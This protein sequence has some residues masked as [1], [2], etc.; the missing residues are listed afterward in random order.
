MRKPYFDGPY[1][2]CSLKRDEKEFFNYYCDELETWKLCHSKA[3]EIKEKHKSSNTRLIFVD[4][5]KLGKVL[6]KFEIDVLF[7]IVVGFSSEVSGVLDRDAVK[8]F[9]SGFLVENS[10]GEVT[11]E[12]S[13]EQIKE[14]VKKFIRLDIIREVHYRGDQ[15]HR[16]LVN[17]WVIYEKIPSDE[18][19][20]EF[21]WS[22]W[23]M[24]EMY[25]KLI[26]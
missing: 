7:R 4:N 24:T 3:E 11:F 22:R 1:R 12:V 21:K 13:P 10:E 5:I 25:D 6:S 17:P 14:C 26:K 23:K 2:Y 9:E 18:V 15:Y 20:D 16:F 8:Y 19:L